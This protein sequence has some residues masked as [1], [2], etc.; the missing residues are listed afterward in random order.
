MA[1]EG[2]WC[3]SVGSLTI[4][5]VDSGRGVGRVGAGGM[6]ERSVLASQLC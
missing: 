3:A 5:N 2:R 4:A 6:R 1:F